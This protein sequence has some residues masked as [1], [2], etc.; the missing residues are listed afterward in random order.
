MVLIFNKGEWISIE[1]PVGSSYSFSEA[2]TYGNMW[3]Y[4]KCVKGMS[5]Q[6]ATQIAEATVM[7]R[8]YPGIKFHYQL[9]E[10]LRMILQP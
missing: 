9:E 10:E 5:E 2:L 1:P 3:V 4:A 6:K 8:L 7:K